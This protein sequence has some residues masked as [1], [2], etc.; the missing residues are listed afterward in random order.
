[1]KNKIS[2]LFIYLFVTCSVFSLNTSDGETTAVY[3]GTT[4][5]TTLNQVYNNGIN[6]LKN[7]IIPLTDP[8]PLNGKLTKQQSRLLWAGLN[9]YNYS[10][11]EFYIVTF[12]PID[13]P[14]QI[15]C[16]AVLIEADGSCT[17][18]GFSVFLKSFY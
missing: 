11:G 4:K 13:S 8:V 17:W 1:M 2:I 7:S 15:Y 3:V 14:T 9:E 6:N 16:F 18:K 5:Q 12:T 10:A